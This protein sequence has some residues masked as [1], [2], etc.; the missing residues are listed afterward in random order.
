MTETR[1]R[2]LVL[3][4]AVG[5][6]GVIAIGTLSGGVSLGR[7]LLAVVAVLPLGAFLPYLARGRRR[8]FAALTLC[9]VLY[10]TLS[11]M[12]VVANP[13]ARLWASLSLLLSFVLFALA[14]VYLRV[15]RPVDA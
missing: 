13:A 15:S 2:A 11:L 12:E 6:I 5:L 14:I 10:L 3:Y 8:S 1:L 4:V 9:L 7:V